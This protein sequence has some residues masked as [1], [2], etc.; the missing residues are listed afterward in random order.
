ML[1][2]VKWYLTSFHVGC[3]DTRAKKPYNPIIGEIFRC[4]W[5]TSLYHNSNIEYNE[6]GENHSAK[7]DEKNASSEDITEDSEEANETFLVTY[8]AEQVS[9]H[10]PGL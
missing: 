6:I 4:S 9:H 3:S 5:Q 2:I 8:T 10:P 7:P 1:A